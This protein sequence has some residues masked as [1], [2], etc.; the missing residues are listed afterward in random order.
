MADSGQ[1]DLLMANMSRSACP[2][3][4]GGPEMPCAN[5]MTGSAGSK[6]GRLEHNRMRRA[7]K[8]RHL[9][10]GLLAFASA[11]GANVADQSE[12]VADP[13][14]PE[15]FTAGILPSPETDKALRQ[16][17]LAA[18]GTAQFILNTLSIDVTDD[19]NP[20]HFAALLQEAVVTA[21]RW[22]RRAGAGVRWCMTCSTSAIGSTIAVASP[23]DDNHARLE[24][25]EHGWLDG[26][27]KLPEIGP[28]TTSRAAF[29]VRQMADQFD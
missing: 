21:V 1:G 9:A 12:W 14:V 29:L 4:I 22:W 23:M 7:N 10:L 27:L 11:P 3:D 26:K 19:G 18:A 2:H 28:G 24:T 8:W 6:L 20:G 13:V 25:R 16:G 15:G 17:T 5:S